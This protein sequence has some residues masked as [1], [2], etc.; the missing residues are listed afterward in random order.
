MILTSVTNAIEE[1]EMAI[2]NIPNT[3]IQ[4]VGT[5]KEKGVKIRICILLVD[6]LVKIAPNIYQDHVLMNKQGREAAIGQVHEC[7]LW[8]ND[9]KPTLLPKNYYHLI[10]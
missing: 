4:T 5:D 1:R 3:F 2:I 6:M 7:S 10:E 9:C 8:N